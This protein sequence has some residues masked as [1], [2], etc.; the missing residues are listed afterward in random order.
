MNAVIIPQKI[1]NKGDLVI[2][3]RKEY[4]ILFNASREAKADWIYEKPV[5]KYINSRINKAESEFRKGK[6]TKWQSKNK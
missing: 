1:A 2:I 5:S 3:P 4:E 6:A